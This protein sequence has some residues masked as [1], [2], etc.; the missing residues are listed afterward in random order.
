MQQ[1]LRYEETLPILKIKKSL[2]KKIEF[3]ILL[4]TCLK[5]TVPNEIPLFFSQQL[6]VFSAHHL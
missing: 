4:S 3:Y 6:H 2:L 1:K 5:K